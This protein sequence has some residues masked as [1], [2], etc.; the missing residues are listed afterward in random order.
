VVSGSGDLYV[1]EDGGD[2]QLCLITPDRVVSP[3]LQL[4]GHPG[5]EITGPAF[6]P[7]ADR[8]FFS[9][10]RGLQGAGIGITFEVRGP[11]R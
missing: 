2:M 11:F 1:A 3:F 5:S 6:S 9:S 4:E 7:A 10:Q 8:L